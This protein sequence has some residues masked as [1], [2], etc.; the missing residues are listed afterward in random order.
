MPQPLLHAAR[1]LTRIVVLDPDVIL[2]DEPFG[3]LDAS[4]QLMNAI[5]DRS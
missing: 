2:M 3:P 5:H 1:E 4:T